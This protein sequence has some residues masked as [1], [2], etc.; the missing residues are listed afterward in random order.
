MASILLI[1]DDHTVADAISF[2]LTRKG[3]EVSH[4]HNTRIARQKLETGSFDCA[5]ID[6]WLGEEDGLEFLSEHLDLFSSTPF[7]VISGGGPG[8]TLENVTARADAYGA[9]RILYK[10][11]EDEELLAALNQTLGLQ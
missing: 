10:P 7:V 5:F 11:F 1:E 2:V 3:H 9:V 4:A 8:R 6:V